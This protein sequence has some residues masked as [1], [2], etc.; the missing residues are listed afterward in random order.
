[1]ANRSEDNSSFDCGYTTP[2]VTSG[3][4]SCGAF[5]QEH[6][7]TISNHKLIYPMSRLVCCYFEVLSAQRRLGSQY[8]VV[9]TLLLEPRISPIA[10][11][12]FD[13]W[14]A[15]RTGSR[16]LPSAKQASSSSIS[17]PLPHH[18]RSHIANEDD[19]K[20]LFLRTMELLLY[21]DVRLE[22]VSSYLLC[23]G[24]WSASSKVRGKASALLINT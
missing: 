9:V 12:Y 14:A 4:L 20:H 16:A 13:V 10:N 18:F 11:R 17:T 5:I 24:A 8:M 2:I 22:G 6:W 23:N 7:P 21:R 15:F 19:K 1:M 3:Q